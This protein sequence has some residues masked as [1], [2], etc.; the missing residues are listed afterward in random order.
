[1]ALIVKAPA[2]QVI[3]GSRAHFLEAGAV[4][5]EGVDQA[6]LDRLVA[7]GFL[8][9]V[10]PAEPEVVEVPKDDADRTD[11]VEPEPV[12]VRATRQSK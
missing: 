7:E 4:V 1:M 12:K 11:E 8:G 5:P 6:V 10:E 2:V 3:V 9:S